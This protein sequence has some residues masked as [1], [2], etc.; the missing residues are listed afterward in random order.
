MA[1]NHIGSPVALGAGSPPITVGVHWDD[2]DGDRGAQWIMA[3]PI[4]PGT[5]AVNN[6]VKERRIVV[7]NKLH[8]FYWATVT[9]IG[10]DDALFTLHGGG[11]A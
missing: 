6:F 10:A 3:D 1:F 9:N 7:P 8:V 5:L 2:G 11:N 4:G